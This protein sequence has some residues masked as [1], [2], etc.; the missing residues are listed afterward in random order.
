MTKPNSR[1]RILSR[2]RQTND[3]AWEAPYVVPSPVI[4]VMPAPENLVS[5]FKQ[6][7]DLIGGEAFLV[8]N[9]KDMLSGLTEVL[10]SANIASV[11]CEDAH[12]GEIL[13]EAGILV[14][15]DYSSLVAV[16]GCD[17]L[18]ARSGSVLVSSLSGKG[19]KVHVSAQTHI[20]LAG[21]SQIRP[22]IRDAIASFKMKYENLPSW[23]TLITGPSRTAD[24]EKTLVT[25]VH[26]PKR[27][28]VFI[29]VAS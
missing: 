16:T 29:D 4:D 19:R 10:K 13:S 18:V 8:E 27:L 21:A 22:F 1:E 23:F 5:T 2:L 9:Q 26:G 17:F 7:L 12:I 3:F 15:Q 28:I 24:I 25:G 14:N 20:V 11:C 6:E